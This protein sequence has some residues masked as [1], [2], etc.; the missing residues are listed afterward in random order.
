MSGAQRRPGPRPRR[1]EIIQELSHA[2]N[3][4]AQRRP[5]PRPR[6]HRNKWDGLT[7]CP[8]S[9]NEG[10]GRDPGDTILQGHTGTEKPQRSTKAGAETPA[11]RANSVRRCRVPGPR[12]TKAGA[13]TPATRGNGHEIIDTANHAQRR[14]GPRPR[15]H[16]RESVRCGR[17]AP[18]LNEG[19]GRDPGDTS[20]PA[21]SA[22]TPPATLNEGR[23]RDPGDT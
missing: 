3:Q 19:R 13:E 15:R 6:R 12:S 5:G 1:H 23:G 2:E 20:T 9:L 17:T 8:A 10:R 18:S 22:S 14:P 11:T 21:R 16:A 4:T 7:R